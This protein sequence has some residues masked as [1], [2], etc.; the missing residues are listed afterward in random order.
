MR[1]KQ[2]I[3]GIELAACS[4]SSYYC[5]SC[6]H[7]TSIAAGRRCQR[8]QIGVRHAC[9]GHTS[10]LRSRHVLWVTDAIHEKV[11]RAA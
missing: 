9:E 1:H 2:G 8:R 6:A 3:D 11:R 5:I 7:A 4:N 10:D